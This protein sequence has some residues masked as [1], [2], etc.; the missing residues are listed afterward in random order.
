MSPPVRWSRSSGALLRNFSHDTL[1]RRLPGQDKAQ[2]A[3]SR[4]RRD[5]GEAPSMADER[6]S[7]RALLLYFLRL[8]T[9][10]FGWTIALAGR[11][12]QVLVEQGGWIRAKENKEGLAFAQLA[13]GTFTAA[14]ALYVGLVRCRVLM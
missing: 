2:V 10:G 3:T 11:M 13:P 9:L 4:R 12:E 14:I 8:G 5:R 1:A 7:L 6:A